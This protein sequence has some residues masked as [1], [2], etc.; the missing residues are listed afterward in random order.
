MDHFLSNIL[1]GNFHDTVIY[2]NPKQYARILR[3]RASRA[4]LNKLNGFSSD[5]NIPTGSFGHMKRE[6]IHQI[7]QQQANKRKRNST[8]QFI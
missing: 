1:H 6:F 4:R 3:R 7:K 5:K 8:G 2:V